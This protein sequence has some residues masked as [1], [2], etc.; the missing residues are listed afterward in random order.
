[1][2]Y[3]VVPGRVEG[4]LARA[5]VD[6]VLQ[7]EAGRRDAVTTHS[8]ELDEPGGRYIDFLV[9]GLLGMGLMGG[10]L[11]GLGFATVDMRIRKLLGPLLA[12]QRS[13][14]PLQRD[15]QHYPRAHR[16]TARR[17]VMLDCRLPASQS[18]DLRLIAGYGIVT[19]LLALRWFRRR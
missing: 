14:D 16:H 1:Y 5:E 4:R 18:P 9:P 2:E 15:S 7:E 6:A 17:A 19:L 11:W 8:E 13:H 10:G 12:S 3:L